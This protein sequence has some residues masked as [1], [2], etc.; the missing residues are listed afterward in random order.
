VNSYF[1]KQGEPDSSAPNIGQRCI[2][3]QRNTVRRGTGSETISNQ[4]KLFWKGC[5]FKKTIPLDADNVATLRLAP[6]YSRFEAFCVEAEA[7][8]NLELEDA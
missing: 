6:G 4:V 1:V 3:M 5:Q 7:E 2:A 8:V